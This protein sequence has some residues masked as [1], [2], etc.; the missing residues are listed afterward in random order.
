M[1]FLLYKQTNPNSYETV[2]IKLRALKP[3]W[4]VSNINEDGTVP[5][6]Q[7]DNKRLISESL[8]VC[9]YLDAAYNGQ[10]VP[11][12]PFEFASHKLVIHHFNK[13]IQLFYKFIGFMA[14]L[15]EEE[16]AQVG[17]KMNEELLRLEKELTDKQYLGGV[18]RSEVSFVV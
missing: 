15:T 18:H 4:F 2:N 3:E 17:S 13:F 10:L 9:D 6:L 16:K 12:D 11:K 5:V 8:F 7:L 1:S 14:K